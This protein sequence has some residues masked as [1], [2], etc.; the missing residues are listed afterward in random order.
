V[1][2]TPTALPQ[3]AVALPLR[4][5]GALN[6]QIFDLYAQM[7]HDECL[8][9]IERA[10]VAP[11]APSDPVKLRTG[12]APA[13]SSTGSLISNPFA[14]AAP[15]VY[16]S[17]Y[18]LYV[19]GLIQRQR[20][21]IGKALESFQA[22]LRVNPRS[23]PNCKQVAR[24]LFLLGRIP[25]ALAVYQQAAAMLAGPDAPTDTECTDAEILLGQ[26]E[27]H[28]RAGNFTE[29]IK[30]RLS[31]GYAC[32]CRVNLRVSDTHFIVVFRQM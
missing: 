1:I 6:G 21:Q 15:P 14:D 30:V 20:A 16:Y 2:V 24:C 28:M 17:D 5:R 13:T 10:L 9:L 18:P 29:A 12:T 22:A 26:G 27:C 11:T 7:Q 3:K 19:R 25:R 8:R 23:V 31:P 4:P 32:A